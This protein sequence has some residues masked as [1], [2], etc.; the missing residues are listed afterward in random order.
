MNVI[1]QHADD[2]IPK[3][4]VSPTIDE[5]L[6]EHFYEKPAD[7]QEPEPDPVMIGLAAAVR[8]ARENANAVVTLSDAAY[9]DPTQ[10]RAAA[11]LQV[12]D[13]ATARGGNVAAK[14]D[15]AMAKATETIRSIETATAAPTAPREAAAIHL[16]AEI[17]ASLKSMKERERKDAINAAFES[18]NMAVVGAI[19]RGPAFLTGTS[20]AELEVVRNR[21]R[22]TKFPTEIARLTRLQKAVEATTAAG[23]S[24]VKLVR[25]A[26]DSP[27]AKSADP[28]K[29][30][31]EETQKE[32]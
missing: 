8:T 13:C 19:L 16:E 17:R 5:R 32:A 20:A 11:A 10:P 24:F 26:A 4:R 2:T 27:L 22:T 6:I 30:L 18:D 29:R 21:Y 3:L 12:R 25:I 7:G 31:R 9:A 15:S 14:I 23:N 1:A 28:A